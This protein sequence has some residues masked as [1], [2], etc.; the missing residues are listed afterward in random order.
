M[1]KLLFILLLS[2][3]FTQEVCEGT[4]LSEEETQGLFNN[5]KELEFKR[6][7]CESAYLNLE[8]QIED[9][10]VSILNYKEQM[11]FCEKQIEIKED[12]IK[13]IKPKWYHNRYLWFF[14]GVFF[15]SGTVYLAGQLD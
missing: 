15:T 6:E 14:S 1:Y 3:S 4:C 13:T 9:Y 5:I 11:K 8:S 7:S 2:F 10:D 12:M